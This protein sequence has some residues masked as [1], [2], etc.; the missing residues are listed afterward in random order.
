MCVAAFHVGLKD[1]LDDLE[2][3]IDNDEVIYHN[4]YTAGELRKLLIQDE[5]PS[6]VDTKDICKLSKQIVDLASDGLNERG[7]GEEIFLKPLYERI[8]GRTNPGKEIISSMHNGC[9][10]EKLIEDYGKLD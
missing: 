2:Y 4:G 9:N 1:N 6:F 8:K 7:I 5:L 10:I 3:I